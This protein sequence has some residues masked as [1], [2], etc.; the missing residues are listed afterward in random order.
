[1]RILRIELDDLRVFL[2][3]GMV[4]ASCVMALAARQKPHHLQ[5][6]E[7]LCRP[8]VCPTIFRPT[9]IR[10]A[11]IR[12]GDIIPDRLLGPRP[13]GAVGWPRVEPHFPELFLRDQQSLRLGVVLRIGLSSDAMT[14]VIYGLT[15]MP[16]V[17]MNFGVPL[18]VGSPGDHP[19]ISSDV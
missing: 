16:G 17:W 10:F 13:Q 14:G 8:V 5:I 12:L 15:M 7:R 18:S 6:E 2:Q 3:G 4:F 19:G 9:G 11:A 1:M